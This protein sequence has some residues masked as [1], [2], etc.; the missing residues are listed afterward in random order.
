MLFYGNRYVGMVEEG[1]AYSFREV[2]A[3]NGAQIASR[4]RWA[5][6]DDPVCCPSGVDV[7]YRH[8]WVNHQL[9]YTESVTSGQ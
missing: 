1:K 5:T 2:A 3:Q 6:P 8:T 9:Q 7:T 4:V